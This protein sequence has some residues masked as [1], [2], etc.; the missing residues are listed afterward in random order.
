MGNPLSAVLAPLFMETLEEDDFKAIIGHNATWL[1]YCDDVITLLPEKSDLKAII[2]ELN[3]SDSSIQFTVEEEH[4]KKIA[5]LDVLVHRYPDGLRFSV[6]RKPANKDDMIHYFSAHSVRVKSGVVIGFYLRALR[7]RSPCFLQDELN[8]DVRSFLR[9]KFPL[10]MLLSLQTTARNIHQRSREQERKF[11]AVIVATPSKF[12]EKVAN[13]VK[14]EV[15][16]I[17]RNG[18]KIRSLVKKKNTIKNSNSLVYKITCGTCQLPYFG[19]SGRGLPTRL[20]EHKADMRHHRIS[21]ALVIHVDSTD[22]LPDWNGAAVI[23]RDLSKLERRAIKAAYITVSENVFLFMYQRI[24]QA[25]S[26]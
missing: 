26:G 3:A 23:H 10:T 1:R 24:L 11:R 19:E 18:S 22:H 16:V 21:N 6:Y 12:T 14:P 2:E 5:F 15:S 4:M 8:Y 17:T 9:L 20:K 25:F 13:S 7:I